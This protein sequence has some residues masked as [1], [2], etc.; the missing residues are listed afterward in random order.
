MEFA[1]YHV[2]IAGATAGETMTRRRA[3]SSAPI[4]LVSLQLLVLVPLFP[5]AGRAG[6]VTP[7]AQ[8]GLA[9]VFHGVERLEW[10][11]CAACWAGW[12]RG[13][14]APGGV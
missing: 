4:G 7:L 2:L 5:K 12:T 8:P 13:S 6:L 1:C 11:G 9:W 10:F 3:P 14:H